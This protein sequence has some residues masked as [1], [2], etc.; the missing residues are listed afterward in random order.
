MKVFS[1]SSLVFVLSISFIW[2]CGYWL[3]L[4]SGSWQLLQQKNELTQQLDK[5]QTLLQNW[6][7]GYQ[8]HLAYLK[9]ELQQVQEL[10]PEGVESA[11]I[12]PLQQLDEQIR[13]VLWPDPLLAYAVLDTQGRVLRLSSADA[14]NYFSQTNFQSK[15]SATFLPPLVFKDRWILPLQVV[16]QQQKLVMWFDADQLQE[17]LQRLMASP[18]QTTEILL[19]SKEAELL[20]R[21]RFQ[22]F[23]LPRLSL[24]TQEPQQALRIYAKRPPENLLRSRQ[25]YQDAGAWPLTSLSNEFRQGN[26]GFIASHYVNYLGRQT[27]A[28][29]R[30]LA[31]WQLYL[32]V[33]RDA[34]PMLDELAAI[35][36]RLLAALVGLSLL[37]SVV[38]Y[39]L[40]RQLRRAALAASVA[41]ISADEV[42]NTEWADPTEQGFEPPMLGA[43]DL[44]TSAE[45]ISPLTEPAANLTEILATDGTVQERIEPHLSEHAP[46]ASSQ[47]VVGFPA[48]TALL[49][50]WLA[51]PHQD[52]KL[53]EFSR[54]WLA[55]VSPDVA[56]QI[57][58]CDMVLDTANMLSQ[59]HLIVAN[60]NY[61]LEPSADFPEALLVQKQRLLPL[62][63]SLLVQVEQRIGSG[64]V[65]VRLMIAET[66]QLRI[67]IIDQ[68]PSLTDVQWLM[69]LEPAAEDRDDTAVAYREIQQ[70]LTE[71]NAHLSARSDMA[72][73]NK[74]VLIIPCEVPAQPVAATVGLVT[75]SAMLL[76]PQGEGQQLYRRLL[77]QSGLDLLPMDDASQLLQ[78][79]ES[80][81]QELSKMLID[82]D[83][84]QSN[85]ALAGKI[86]AVVRRYFPEV[87]VLLI[88]R[89]PQQWLELALREQMFLLVKPM[90]PRLLIEAFHR[91]ST[92]IV[93]MSAA[94]IWLWQPD[95]LQYWWIEQQLLSL[96]VEVKTIA[97]LQELPGNLQHDY[98]CLPWS[99]HDQLTS[100]G[101]LPQFVVWSAEAA[102]ESIPL[103]SSHQLW[104]MVDGSSALSRHLH[105]IQLQHQG[106]NTEAN[107]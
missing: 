44:E 98:Y 32:V 88:V 99:Y 1:W 85:Q 71:L 46:A 102:P 26:S 15:A 106:R 93:T 75:G 69:V 35:K 22:K 13:R 24:D 4:Q 36:M 39:L 18:L 8:L 73:G 70:Q 31:D 59:R 2:S 25:H 52:P 48:A 11:L 19:L 57:W 41:D 28:S 30:E 50:A 72:A 56:D 40:I 7:Q 77:K 38:F 5:A 60:I 78:W 45:N 76:C 94:T 49:Q 100:D 10:P 16:Q 42:S 83:F 104:M 61:V 86:A 17:Q 87:Q 91:S 20:S 103:V 74:M 82:E 84:M 92:G 53:A 97:K 3:L 101:V 23:L 29:F 9:T 54:K 33:E 105:H 81:P 6:Q 12:D 47:T 51:Q 89:Q 34:G 67:E 43:L 95:P 96:N 14:S 79:C 63:Q 62:L 66:N 55:Q 58:C 65:V 107:R 37:L 64:T 68:S 90:T 27:L 80:S 21:S